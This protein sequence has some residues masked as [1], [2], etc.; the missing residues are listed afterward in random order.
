MRTGL[1][2][3]ALVLA[4]VILGA[5]SAAAD[6][7]LEQ[8]DRDGDGYISREEIDAYRGGRFESWDLNGDGVVSRDEMNQRIR[9][10]IEEKVGRRFQE[11]DTNGNGRIERSEYVGQKGWS[12]DDLDRDGDGLISPD[13]LRRARDD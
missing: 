6:S 3:G 9:E 12:F 5:G 2:P 7:L 13:E 1:V 11:L 8:I 10:R 4:V